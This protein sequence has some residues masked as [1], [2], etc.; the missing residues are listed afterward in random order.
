[1]MKSINVNIGIQPQDVA[2]LYSIALVLAYITIFYNVLEGGVSVFFGLQ[3]ETVALFGFGLDSFVEVISGIGILHMVTRIKRG[4]VSSPDKFEATAL[5]I[6]GGAFYLLTASLV[7]TAALNLALGNAPQTTFWGIVIS[8]ISILTMWILIHYK[9]K[10]GRALNSDA[11]I[12]DANCTRVCLILSVVLLVSSVGYE[13]TGIGGVDSVGALV[14]AWYAFREGKESFE[15][16]QGKLCSC[17][18]C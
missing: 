14:I 1:M 5:R 3:D 10:V 17:N 4:G 8:L 6:T 9:L 18:H 15:K 7:A 2:R 13:L 16:A 12:A 11:I